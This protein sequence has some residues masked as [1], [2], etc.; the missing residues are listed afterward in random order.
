M[1]ESSSTEDP[2]TSVTPD[3]TLLDALLSHPIDEDRRKEIFSSFNI[4]ST[5]RGLGL[6]LTGIGG[7]ACL[8]GPG[9][10][11]RDEVVFV[12]LVRDLSALFFDRD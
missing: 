5:G 4:E 1:V 10:R 9:V 2:L 3:M 11:P 12:S 8:A 6:H 7:L